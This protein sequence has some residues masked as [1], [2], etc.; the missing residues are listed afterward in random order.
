[1][2]I[3][4]NTILI[5]GGGSGIGRALAEALH[6]KGN[7]VIIAGRRESVLDDVTQAHPGMASMLLDIQDKADIAAFAQEAVARF[8]ALNVVINNAGIM[9][10]ETQIDLAIAEE[11]IATNLLGP[12]R[13]TAALLPHL[14]AQPRAAIVTVSSG[15]AF[16]PMAATPTYSATKAAIHSWSMALRYQ[17]RDTSVEVVEIAPPYVQT[18]LLGAHQLT[19][20][21]AMPLADF[22][23]EVMAIL[24]DAPASGEVIVERC[25]PLRFA[26][27]NGNFAGVFAMVNSRH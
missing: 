3:T 9:R 25:K 20:P 26:E 12:I 18:E 15:L 19:D 23:D 13:L 4:G 16:V 11:T 21:D 5:T 22:T 27:E 8:P 14:K 1:M 17:L 7:T 10:P 24:E 2:N 6:A